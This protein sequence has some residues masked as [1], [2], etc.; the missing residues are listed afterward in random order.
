MAIGQAL[1]PY[2]H[3]AKQCEILAHEQAK[4]HSGVNSKQL[5][6]EVLAMSLS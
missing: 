1:K 3:H 4:S 5:F 6:K 2:K